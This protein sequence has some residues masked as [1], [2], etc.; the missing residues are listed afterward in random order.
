MAR[1][2]AERVERELQRVRTGP[3]HPGAYDLKSHI[4]FSPISVFSERTRMRMRQTN[5]RATLRKT[6]DVTAPELL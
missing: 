3:A 1:A 4:V 6:K 5:R 2:K